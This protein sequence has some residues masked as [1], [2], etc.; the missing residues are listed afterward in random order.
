MKVS[1]N[2]IKKYVKIPRDLSTAD[3]VKL[4]GS[5]LVEV[6]GTEDWGAKYRGIYIVKVVECEPIPDTHL[7][8]CQIDA[9]VLGS[10]LSK[11]IPHPP[12]E[13]HNDYRDESEVTSSASR[14]TNRCDFDK[15]DEDHCEEV[16]FYA[17]TSNFSGYVSDSTTI[18]VNLTDNALSLWSSTPSHIIFGTGL[19][20][21]GMVLY[22]NNKTSSP[23]EII[24]NQYASLLLELGLIGA[25]LATLPLITILRLF[26]TSPLAPLLIPLCLAYVASL[27]FFAGLPNALHIYLIPSVLYMIP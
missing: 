9:G 14:R 25:L 19:G 26:I 4:I 10:G 8:L 7:H 16:G 2:E 3:L 12:S 1:L 20:S 23:K 22:E 5:R 13:N 6:E 18:R 17:S 24:Q 27:F 21:A 11:S 15:V